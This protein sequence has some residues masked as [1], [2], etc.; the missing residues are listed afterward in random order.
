[1]QLAEP[2]AASWK[3]RLSLHFQE[4]D[5][6]T[7]LVQNR[8]DGPLVVQKPLYPEGGQVCHAIVVH[9]PAGMAGG[10]DLE[11]NVDVRENAQVLLTTPGAGKWYRSAGP[12]AS[13]H[14]RFRVNG[15]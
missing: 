5:S 11:L 8:S 6:R 13:Q 7:V 3:A 9:P 2:L 15:A 4:Q 1:M 12:W 14:L 10:D